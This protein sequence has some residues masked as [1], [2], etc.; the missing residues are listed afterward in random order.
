MNLQFRNFQLGRRVASIVLF[1]GVTILLTHQIASSV[2]AEKRTSSCT[3]L[4]V[5][6][7][8]DELSFTAN[9]A[10]LSFPCTKNENVDFTCYCSFQPGRQIRSA[11]FDE[12]SIDVLTAKLAW[13]THPAYCST[14]ASMWR[15]CI[16]I[17][18][19]KLTI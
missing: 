4:M 10:A 15:P 5:L 11:L 19:R 6:P 16:L 13:F 9:D 14:L 3:G 17:A 12:P 18:Q 7:A 2:A 1:I 8:L